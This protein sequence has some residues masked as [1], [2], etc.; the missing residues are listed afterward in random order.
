MTKT[1]IEILKRP[2]DGRAAKWTQC[3]IWE[4]KQQGLCNCNTFIENQVSGFIRLGPHECSIL[5]VF[6]KMILAQEL[7]LPITQLRDHRRRA[8]ISERR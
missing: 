6:K 2:S 7:K 1:A 5:V 3:Q 4:R 8:A